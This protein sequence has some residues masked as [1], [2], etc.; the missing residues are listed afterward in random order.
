MPSALRITF[1]CLLCFHFARAQDSV[2][3]SL[4]RAFE[5]PLQ[6][7]ILNLKG[8]NVRYIPD[9]FGRFENLEELDLSDNPKIQTLPGTLGQLKK[10]R[11]LNM[12]NCR[13]FYGIPSALGDASSLERLQLSNCDIYDIPPHLGNLKNLYHLELEANHLSTLPATLFNLK[14]LRTLWLPKNPIDSLPD[15]VIYRL[16]YNQLGTGN[17]KVTEIVGDFMKRKLDDEKIA[18]IK[19][20]EE[21][22]KVNRRLQEEAKIRKAQLNKILRLNS[23]QFILLIISA[24]LIFLL[25]IAAYFIR[26]TRLREKAARKEIEEKNAAIEVSRSVLQEKNEALTASEEELRQQ[27]EELEAQ[28]D[29]LESTNR[30]LGEQ[31]TELEELQVTK[32]LM[33]SAI[34]HDLRNPLNPIK[35]YS[36]PHYPDPDKPALLA[37]IHRKSKRMFSMIEDIMDVYRAERL[38]LKRQNY[39]PHQAVAEAI[40]EVRDM[41]DQQ[42]IPEIINAIP[43]QWQA[44]FD[45][46]S[47]ERVLENLLTNAIKYTEAEGS[48]S[49]HTALINQEGEA[50]NIE[51]IDQASYLEL[52]ITDTGQGISESQ[53]KTIFQPFVNPNARSLGSAKS[54]GI[55]LTFCKTV[56]EA[57]GSQLLI[58]SQEGKGSTFSFR[59][60]LAQSQL[61]VPCEAKPQQEISLNPVERELLQ[62]ILDQLKGLEVEDTSEVENLLA[63]IDDTTPAIDTWKEALQEALDDLDEVAYTNLLRQAQISE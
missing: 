28:R 52:A 55:G 35:N 53:L 46:E 49:F 41:M 4:E 17:E 50:L 5:E 44:Y 48:I 30:I 43:P 3:Y 7:K 1:I 2:Y 63:A 37:L 54:V 38:Q 19:E 27:A 26:K 8:K 32:D 13:E 24:I 56:V 62:P 39:A 34:N 18:L 12:R 16:V 20:K 61:L 42:D 40:R 9:S 36:S 10:L 31:K 29:K 58:E 57:H 60:P 23:I 6:V 21:Q 47:I 59:L 22:A 25:L 45:Y 14:K 33:I 51:N 15:K 11:I